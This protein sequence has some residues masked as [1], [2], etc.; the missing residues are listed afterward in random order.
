MKRSARLALFVCSALML[1]AVYLWALRWLPPFGH[2]QGPYGD[3]LN[4]LAVFERHVTNVVVA[5]TFDYRALDTLGEEFI[6]AI[7]IVGVVTLLRVQREERKDDGNDGANSDGT[8]GRRAVEPSDAAKVLT[9]A[10]IGPMVV[11]GVY[12]ASHGQLT[13]GGGFQGGVILATAPLLVYLA[14]DYKTFKQFSSHALVELVEA[15][16]VFGFVAIGLAALVMGAN[17]LQNIAWLG[18]TGAINS[19]GTITLISLSVAL[20]VAGGFILLLRQFLEQALEIRS[21]G[22]GR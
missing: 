14:G 1:L 22:E 7:C 5:V 6:L 9:L 10:L 2:Y 18:T 21:E 11:F 13:P 16:G 12:I 19:G 17:F 20:A 15:A 8:S 3:V 4:H